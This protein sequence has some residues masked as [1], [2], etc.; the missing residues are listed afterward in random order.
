[1]ND[2]LS[3]M[4]SIKKM[5]N[6]SS[7]LSM[8]PGMGAM[9]DKITNSASDQ[10]MRKTEAIICSMTTKERVDPAIINGPRKKRLAM[11]SGTTINDVNILMKQYNEASKMIKKLGKMDNKQALRM[12]KG[13]GGGGAVGG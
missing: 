9:K 2:L 12:F 4:R 7:L 13:M 3:Q 8:I 5:G 1:M 10:L 6:I 11:G